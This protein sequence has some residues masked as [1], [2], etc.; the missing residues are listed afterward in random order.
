MYYFCPS[1]PFISNIVRHQT[2]NSK[3]AP[4]QSELPPYYWTTGVPDSALVAVDSVLSAIR[5]QFPRASVTWTSRARD[6]RGK[7]RRTMKRGEGGKSW[8]L[9]SKEHLT[10]WPSCGRE[11][12]NEVGRTL[13]WCRWMTQTPSRH[14]ATSSWTRPRPGSSQCQLSK[15]GRILGFCI[16]VKMLLLSVICFVLSCLL[17]TIS[18]CFLICCLIYLANARWRQRRTVRATNTNQQSIQDISCAVVGILIQDIFV[19][20][21]EPNRALLIHYIQMI[22]DIGTSVRSEDV[23]KIK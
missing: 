23:F 21:W 4:H 7:R 14:M 18:I 8:V 17:F 12:Q 2:P 1:Q 5:I 6:M 16:P 22:N 15:E 9:V 3:F 13:S 19:L 11:C 10:E 20:V